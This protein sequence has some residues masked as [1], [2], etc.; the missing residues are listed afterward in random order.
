MIQSGPVSIIIVRG[1]PP[2]AVL[3]LRR[4]VFVD[5]QAVP[6][7]LEYDGLDATADHAVILDVDGRARAT[8]RLVEP[9]GSGTPS[10][11]E[12]SRSGSY[13]K[14]GRVAVR[15]DQR[16]R[17]LG[18]AVMGALEQRA[19]ERGLRTI[20]LHA[21]VEVEPFYLRQGYTSEGGHF[22]VAGIEHVVMHKEL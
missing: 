19:R 11:G 16:R 6:A 3:D 9:D 2:R 8:A 20:V 7:D 4:A 10:G 13:G 21:Q 14:I 5:E 18:V 1:T 17:G 12:S 22:F 15:A